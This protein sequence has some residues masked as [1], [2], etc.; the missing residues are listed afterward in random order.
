MRTPSAI[1]TTTRMTNATTKTSKPSVIGLGRALLAPLF[2]R[3]ARGIA[4]PNP[5][6]CREALLAAENSDPALPLAF[7]DMPDDAHALLAV[8]EAG[9]VG[10]LLAA[11]RLEIVPILAV[12]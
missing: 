8:V 9:Q 12:E 4:K 3:H 6:W 7:D 1:V 10:E 11:G 2:R 5:E